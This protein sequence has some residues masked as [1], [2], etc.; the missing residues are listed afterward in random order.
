M[1]NN[2]YM[3][4]LA[5]LSICYVFVLTIDGILNYISY[6]LLIYF[7][8]EHEIDYNNLIYHAILIG[9][10]NDFIIMGIFGISVL[11]IILFFV[12]KK[13]FIRL[14]D[15]EN[16]L[17]KLLYSLLSYTIYVALFTIF[18][19]LVS[20]SDMKLFIIPCIVNAIL[21]FFVLVLKDYSY[22]VSL[23]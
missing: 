19:G 7:L 12:L 20:V 6:P 5:T 4:L 10:F 11:S 21:F 3:K 8:I 17:V 2:R 15:Y 16:I 23:S 18:S 22:A 1:I 13:A 9:F 14:L